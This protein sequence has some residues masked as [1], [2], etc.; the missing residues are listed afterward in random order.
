MLLDPLERGLG[1]LHRRELAGAIEFDE[2]DG[3]Q[4]SGILAHR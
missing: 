1:R 3:G 2:F 4:Q